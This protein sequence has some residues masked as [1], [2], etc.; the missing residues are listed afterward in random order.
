MI[1]FSSFHKLLVKQDE[2]GLLSGFS[3][4][5]D[6][7]KAI[8]N[9]RQKIRFLV[10]LKVTSCFHLKVSGISTKIFYFEFSKHFQIN[11]KPN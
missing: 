7:G 11:G 1:Q 9:Y 3:I 4:F 10:K 8:K 2:E 6:T 5:Y